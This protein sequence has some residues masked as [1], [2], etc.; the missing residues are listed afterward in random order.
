MISSRDWEGEVDIGLK[1][2]V[3]VFFKVTAGAAKYKPAPLIIGRTTHAK[4]M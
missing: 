4:L 1:T 3:T 2:R